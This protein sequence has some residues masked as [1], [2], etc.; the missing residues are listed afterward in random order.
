MPIK[1]FYILSV[2]LCLSTAAFGAEA[3]GQSE[4]LS[5]FSGAFG[6]ALWT[7]ITFVVLLLALWKLVWKKVIEGLNWRTEHIEK[8]ISDAEQTR[9]EADKVLAE[10]K[11]K[12]AS[13]EDEGK[14]I[15]ESHVKKA[16]QQGRQVLNKAK[17]DMEAMKQKVQ[18]DIAR[19]NRQAQAELL[20]RSGE[21]VLKLGQEILGKNI[22][23][24]DNQRLI[25][26]AIERLKTEEINKDT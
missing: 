3:S 20:V 24:Q 21:I 19:A 9:R 17:D 14:K 25:D 5:P 13:V 7:V 2:V 23:D 8:Q 22:N 4:P 1:L 26:Q 6:D 18:D 11:T 10:Y 15:I 12:L 16:E